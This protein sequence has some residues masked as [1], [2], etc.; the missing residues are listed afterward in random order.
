M[1]ETEERQKGKVYLSQ[2][3]RLKWTPSPSPFCLKVETW[4]RMMDIPYEVRTVVNTMLRHACAKF[5]KLIAK[6]LQNLKTMKMGKVG[7]QKPWVEF[8]GVEIEE[9]DNIIHVLSKV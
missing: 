9:S 5:E 6:V 7:G 2:F 4:L 1:P 3:P 8:N